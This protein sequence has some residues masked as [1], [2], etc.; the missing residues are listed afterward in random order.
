MSSNYYKYELGTLSEILKGF[1]ANIP[2]GS[3][4]STT[5]G[6][7]NV[8]PPSPQSVGQGDKI[9]LDAIPLFSQ[10]FPKG[11]TNS[12][13]NKQAGAYRYLSLVLNNPKAGSS[14]NPGVGKVIPGFP[15]ILLSSGFGHRN[16]G[17]KTPGRHEGIDIAQIGGGLPMTCP[18]QKAKVTE[19]QS[20]YGIMTLHELDPTTDKETGRGCRF[21][22]SPTRNIKEN[23]VIK[24]GFVVG[25]EGRIG[26][27]G[28]VNPL[29]GVHSHFEM[30]VLSKGNTTVTVDGKSTTPS[31]VAKT[32]FLMAPTLEEIKCAHGMSTT[33]LKL[34]VITISNKT[35]NYNCI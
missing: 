29:Y 1:I 19:S 35:I 13:I 2:L 9:R 8:I 3:G 32:R 20:N 6:S 34:P 15:K 12:D 24:F 14:P 21:L 18:F 11:Q 27:G 31:N 16:H 5:P 7:G 26:A 30:F 22:H 28:V 25:V 23:D 33:S 17:Q 4:G 10:N